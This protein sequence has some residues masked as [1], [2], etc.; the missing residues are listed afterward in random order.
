MMDSHQ[1]VS[2]LSEFECRDQSSGLRVYGVAT[3]SRLDKIM[4]L[5]CQRA[6]QTRLYSAQETYNSIDPTDCSHPI[7]LGVVGRSVLV[8]CFRV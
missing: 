8:L 2:R 1:R 3:V 6:I 7:G 4:D 5:L